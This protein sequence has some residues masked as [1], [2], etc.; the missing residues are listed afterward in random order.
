MMTDAD[1]HAVHDA[2]PEDAALDICG[3]V[4]DMILHRELTRKEF[5]ALATKSKYWFVVGGQ[6]GAT[7]IAFETPP[8]KWFN[9]SHAKAKK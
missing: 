1:K 5:D 8:A 9:S 4:S 7:K 2:T 6:Q 3:Y